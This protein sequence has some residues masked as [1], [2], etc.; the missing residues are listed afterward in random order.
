MPGVFNHDYTEA[1]STKPCSV[2]RAGEVKCLPACVA[3]FWPSVR[4]LDTLPFHLPAPLP[5]A[6]SCQLPGN[7]AG[8]RASDTLIFLKI[9]NANRGKW[10]TCFPICHLF[11]STEHLCNCL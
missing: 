8:S 6:W 9:K 11:H 4:S 5:G 1:P 2:C 10:E 3:V 7:R